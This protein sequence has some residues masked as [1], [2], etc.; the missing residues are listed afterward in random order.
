M[1][2]EPDYEAIA[3]AMHG[4]YERQAERFDRGRDKRLFE[5]KWL[6]RFNAFLPGHASVLDLGCGTGEPISNFF[7]KQNHNITGYDYS[8]S[9]IEIASSRFPDHEWLVGDM[10]SID[11]DRKYDGIVGWHSFFHLTREEQ[12]AALPKIAALLKPG[13][14][15]MV[16]IGPDDGEVTGMVGGEHVYHAS[17]AEN[18]Y[19]QILDS[20]GL[21]V[22]D[23]VVEDPDCGMNSVMLAKKQR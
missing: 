20:V 1:K 15:L 2:R 4:V 13:G 14:L 3:A 10:R 5:R 11:L 22:V 19:R 7:I 8:T 21:E 9:M 23:F 16:T 17:L 12:R 6:R 18:E